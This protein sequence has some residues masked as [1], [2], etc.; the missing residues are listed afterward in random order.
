[1]SEICRQ[2]P[3]LMIAAP[4]SGSGK[5]MICCGLLHALGEEMKIAAFK[6]GPDYIDPMFHQ[7][8][9]GVPSRNLDTFFTDEDTTRYLMAEGAAGRDMALVEGVMGYYDGLGGT[10]PEGSSYDLSVKTRTPV[11]L[12]VDG[13]GA[14]L[15]I[16]A[17]IKG[18][19]SFRPDQQ[20]R[21]V[22]L[23]RTSKAVY[24]R[25]APLIENELGVRTA[26]YV[27]Q[28]EM[29]SFPGRYLGLVTPDELADLKER[30]AAFGQL[31]K[32]TVDIS[33]LKEIAAGAPPLTCTEPETDQPQQSVRIGL[34]R[35]EAFCFYYEDNLRLLERKGAQILAF[36]PLHD[37]HL[38]ENLDGLYIG[39]GYPELHARQLSD[40][41]SMLKAVREALDEGVPCIA[42]CGGY[43]YLQ[44]E[45]ED[46]AGRMLPMVGV[47]EGTARKKERL[48][49]FG[50]QVLTADKPSV[51]GPAGITLKA[52][53]F[54]YYDVSPQGEGFTA[55][56]AA[57]ES[58]WP[59]ITVRDNLA[60][61]FPHLYFYAN[62]AAAEHFV[63]ACAAYKRKNHR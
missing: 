26:G 40:N 27:P 54:H 10:L 33:L 62:P 4:K 46:D 16:L 35:D 12:V 57:G 42:E 1:M 28:T 7:T 19:I 23:N 5:T 37:R 56:K 45:M 39:G 58:S 18:F 21:A 63:N 15:S 43:M 60:A 13:K 59:A 52:H 50:Y 44:R 32:T 49:R 20:I 38:P 2:L 9:L 22:I 36:S 3:R 14:S 48:V 31:L 34:A 41:Q 53:E 30:I 6:C 47:L 17:Q 24:E 29:I 11:V 51:L 25:L 61:G 55:R 8:V